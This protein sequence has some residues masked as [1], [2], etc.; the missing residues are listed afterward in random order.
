MSAEL[1]VGKGTFVLF[2]FKVLSFPE[3]LAI[4]FFIGM[5]VQVISVVMVVVNGVFPKPKE[6]FLGRLTD[7]IKDL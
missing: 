7:V 5:Y 2:G 6:D 3:W 4:S 1:L